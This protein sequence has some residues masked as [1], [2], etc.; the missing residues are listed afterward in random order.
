M[1]LLVL[2]FGISFAAAD[3]GVEIEVV[4]NFSKP[5]RVV[6]EIWSDGNRRVLDRVAAMG[7]PARFSKSETA[8]DA[9]VKSPSWVLYITQWCAY[10]I[11]HPTEK[12]CFLAPPSF[13]NCAPAEKV[14]RCSYRITQGE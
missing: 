14:G 13:G 5:Q 12:T 9:K 1:F 8:H 2:A 11:H 6:L 3:Q 4:N 7:N 10:Q